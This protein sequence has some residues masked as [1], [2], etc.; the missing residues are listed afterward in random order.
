LSLELSEEE[1]EEELA[2][3][4]ERGPARGLKATASVSRAI[5]RPPAGR[6]TKPYTPAAASDVTIDPMSGITV[7]AAIHTP[8][9]NGVTYR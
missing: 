9:R 2:R 8:I 4:R 3:Q 7:V 1:I 5:I 6:L